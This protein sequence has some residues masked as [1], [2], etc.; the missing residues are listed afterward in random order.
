MSQ[1]IMPSGEIPQ[2]RPSKPCGLKK[3]QPGSSGLVKLPSATGHVLGSAGS[4][5]AVEGGQR[6]TTLTRPKIGNTRT[7]NLIAHPCDY[8][9]F[10][11][12]PFNNGFVN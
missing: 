5:P 9:Q 10:S 1:P 3:I 2:P 12:R 6:A 11:L 7:K 8:R 4:A